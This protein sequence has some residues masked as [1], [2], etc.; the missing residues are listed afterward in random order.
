MWPRIVWSYSN[1]LWDEKSNLID[2]KTFCTHPDWPWGPPS[3][4]YN[5]YQVVPGSKVARVWC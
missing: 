3:L 5:W 2:E 4:L 1:L